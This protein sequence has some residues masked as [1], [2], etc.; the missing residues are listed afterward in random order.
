MN[1]DIAAGRYTRALFQ[2]AEK[3]K[4]LAEIDSGLDAIVKVLAAQPKI[5]R[6]MENPSLS[7]AEKYSLALAALAGDKAGLFARFLRLLV[8]KKRFALLPEIQ[9]DFHDRFEK[10]QGIQEVEMFSA[11]PFSATALEKF[12]AA[13]T[14]KLNS[15]IRLIPRT[16]RGLLGGFVLRFAGQEI[17]CSFKNR[18]HEIRQK[19]F[20]SAEEGV[21]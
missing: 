8:E 3:E 21:L 5:L 1:N 9:K 17:D 10:K 11:V 19:L 18:L 16:D 7:D 13:L 2:L 20:S 14:K 12:K 6:L 15:K 4:H